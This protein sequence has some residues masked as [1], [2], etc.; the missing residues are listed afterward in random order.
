[1]FHIPSWTGFETSIS[2]KIN[3]QLV[4]LNFELW[5]LNFEFWILNF[6]EKQFDPIPFHDKLTIWATNKRIASLT[7]I[8]LMSNLATIILCHF[9]GPF[10]G[11]SIFYFFRK[12]CFIITLKGYTARWKHPKPNVKVRNKDPPT[13]QRQTPR[14]QVNC[15]IIL[16]VGPVA[17]TPP[18]TA[19]LLYWQVRDLSASLFN[20]Q[21]LLTQY[22]N[23]KLNKKLRNWEKIVT[24]DWS[25]QLIFT[26]PFG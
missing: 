5:T 16:C 14:F 15:V 9:C 21:L 6:E 24:V 18:H 1:M 11:H 3:G 7:H 19:A 12:R 17:P 25:C 20:P 4:T 22:L 10:L 26:H 8:T 2:E 13:L 23:F